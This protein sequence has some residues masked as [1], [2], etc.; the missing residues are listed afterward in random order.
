MSG[1]S[2]ARLAR[3][4]VKTMLHRV[5]NLITALAV[6][7]AVA[8][9]GSAGD[10][11]PS[12]AGAGGPERAARS[13]VEARIQEA[14]QE[15]G[16]EV[17]LFYRALDGSDSILVNPDLRMHAASTMKVPV[18][19]QLFLD[20]DD[21]M[22][23]LDD[24]IPVDPTFNSIVDG[25]PFELSVDSDSEEA[26]YSRIGAMASLRELNELMI[27]VSSNFAT[28]LLIEH[29]DARRVNST[30]RELGADSIQVLRGVE[31]L[32]AFEAGLSNTTTARDLAVIMFALGNR[33]VGGTESAAEMLE[34]L[35]RQQF[36]EK[37]PAGLPP[38][39]QVAHKTGNIT[40]ISHDAA[41]VYPPRVEPYVLV[42]MI[43][44][45]EDEDRSASLAA[46]LSGLIYGY[47]TR[48]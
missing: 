46:D 8:A 11:E 41:I 4:P 29:V 15:S 27:T 6:S 33:S 45:L 36:R 30:M 12:D 32:K 14:I 1:R 22:L 40:A 10:G 37:I 31:D 34:V 43:R 26:L 7:G 25:S 20:R 5:G 42:V 17:G 35:K 3:L 38:G 16:A 47:H 2:R 48:G 24:S 28:N 21:G 13:D 39:I 9:C 18:M 44:G 19:I 23:S